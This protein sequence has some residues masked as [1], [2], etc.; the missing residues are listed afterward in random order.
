MPCRA[1]PTRPAD[2][3]AGRALTARPLALRRVASSAAPLGRA[4]GGAGAG[5]G[6]G[7]EADSAGKAEPERYVTAE[8]E[9][10]AVEVT[11]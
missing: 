11:A 7:A 1:V 8:A 3:S 9:T 6:A 2:R 4:A 10:K 5:A